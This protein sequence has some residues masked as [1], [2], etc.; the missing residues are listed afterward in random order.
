MKISP[1]L[2]CLKWAKGTYPTPYGVI[3]IE[4]KVVDG[5]V[6]SVINAPD[7]VEIVRG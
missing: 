7:E 4:H 2:A 3:E 6:E 1:N 5:K